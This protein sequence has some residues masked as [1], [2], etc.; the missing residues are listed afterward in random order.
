MDEALWAVV[1][2][3]IDTTCRV[4][5][6]YNCGHYPSHATGVVHRLIQALR[7][8]ETIE[9]RTFG[10]LP[11]FQY[12][13]LL[14]LVRSF[15]SKQKI[16][17]ASTS[18]TTSAS[19]CE[20][21]LEAAHVQLHDIDPTFPSRALLEVD[22][23][24]PAVVIAVI[25]FLA[26]QCGDIAP[27][28]IRGAL[29]FSLDH[30][31]RTVVITG[32]KATTTCDTRNPM[33]DA[34]CD[35][36]EQP[37]HINKY[38]KQLLLRR[39]AAA[40]AEMIHKLNERVSALSSGRP[41]TPEI[42]HVAAPKDFSKTPQPACESF[43]E[44]PEASDIHKASQRIHGSVRTRPVS[45]GATRILSTIEQAALPESSILMKRYRTAQSVAKQVQ[46]VSSAI[47]ELP[48]CQFRLPSKQ[49]TTNKEIIELLQQSAYAERDAFRQLRRHELSIKHAM[50]RAE[51]HLDYEL[52]TWS[53]PMHL[54]MP[55]QV[56]FTLPQKSE[57][58][59]SAPKLPQPRVE[60]VT[61]NHPPRTR[62]DGS[63]II[64]PTP[65]SLERAQRHHCGSHY[66]VGN[67]GALLSDVVG[68]TRKYGAQ[69]LSRN[70][71]EQYR[72][73]GH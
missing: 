22:R 9:L 44:D 40:R 6:N 13:Q 42:S 65:L 36:W 69:R 7:V 28:I 73:K 51:S 53:S 41:Q 14:E 60:R 34:I 21:A 45:A 35:V 52:Q 27:I 16:L 50:S 33:G 43:N 71:A 23:V 31:H 4:L 63:N 24:H 10:I 17:T 61:V 12:S 72:K 26:D 32:R 20:N 66:P 25:T 70:L 59:I 48:K 2:D 57:T 1:A 64:A 62:L 49:P 18:L 46:S 29:E 15:C 30:F 58:R 56:P 19:V 39:M 37:L 11:I 68:Q 55:P 5:E 47:N 54:I 38:F 3:K 67:H 8:K